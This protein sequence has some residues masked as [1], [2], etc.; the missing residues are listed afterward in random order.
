MF[1]TGRASEKEAKEK[2]KFK[3]RRETILSEGFTV[4][5]TIPF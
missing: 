3:L 5:F 4:D 2:R 1:A